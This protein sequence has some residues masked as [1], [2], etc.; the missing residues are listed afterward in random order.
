MK[1]PT[2][3]GLDALQRDDFKPLHDRRVGLVT[4]H[5]GLN[6]EGMA[7][8]DL[9]HAHP[10]V[11]LTALFGPE[12]GIRGAVDDKVADSVDA[13]TG[14]PVYS[15]YGQRT[16]PLPEQLA[17]LD[18]LVFDIQDVGARYYTYISTL[19]LCQEAAAQA[20]LPFL[21]LDRPNPIGGL[22]VEGPLA[23]SD[24]LSFTAHY[25]IPVRHG[26]TVGEMARL[27]QAEKAIL[28]PANETPSPLIIAHVE[29]WRRGEAWDQTGLT[30]TNP[31]PNM[32]SLAQA[33]LYPGVGLLEFTNVSVG[34][35][36]D[37]PFEIIG[38]P[39][40]NGR[41][42]AQHLN[43]Q[44]LPGVRF[45]PIHFTPHASKFANQAC[46]GVNIIITRRDG[47]RPVRLGFA[48]ACGLRDLHPHEWEHANYIRLLANS[49]VYNAL[50][51]GADPAHLE[52]LCAPDVQA[53]RK[54]C[55]GHLL[56]Q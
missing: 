11:H 18:M 47:F 17:N 53:F 33:F 56:Y 46:G 6:S 13:Q 49:S 23:D 38:A 39:W 26:L 41:Q 7:T 37:T 40:L 12:H 43:A 4:N 30:W 15:L 52:Q 1:P 48:L 19:G 5:T 44:N 31:S 25:P 16:R 51:Q 29:N 34:R 9:L 20:R 32:R 2:L 28:S 8:A 42:L 3:T 36:T 55:A 45:V 22:A 14:L 21:V 24:K 50:L 35:G 27:F 54:R 10:K